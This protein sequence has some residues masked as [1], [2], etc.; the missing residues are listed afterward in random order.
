MH[1]GRLLLVAGV[2]PDRNACVYGSRNSKSH[3]SWSRRATGSVRGGA[4]ATTVD[5]LPHDPSQRL[6]VR[7]F[8][9]RG[10]TSAARSP[11]RRD[12]PGLPTRVRR[13]MNGSDRPPRSYATTWRPAAVQP[14]RQPTPPNQYRAQSI[15]RPSHSINRDVTRPGRQHLKHSGQPSPRLLEAQRRQ[16]ACIEGATSRATS[17]STAK[18]LAEY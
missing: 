2:N 6:Q 1:L 3:G 10:P 8:R 15:L 18:V 17:N 7:S 14:G 5:R 9:Q 12:C 11:S 4:P 13:A 16:S